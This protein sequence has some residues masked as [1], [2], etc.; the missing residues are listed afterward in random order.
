MN[1]MNIMLDKSDLPAHSLSM[2]GALG[3]WDV[4]RNK[5]VTLPIYV[6]YLKQ[7]KDKDL[8]KLVNSRISTVR[9]QISKIQNLF[10]EHDFEGPT[11]P[12]WEK[13]LNNEP[14]VLSG[15]ILD[16]EEIAMGMKELIR[17][18]IGLET[19]ALRNATIPEVRNLIF[20]LMK[21]GNGDYSSIIKLQKEKGWTDNPP[22]LVQQ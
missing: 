20:S 15:S 12:N 7:V 1:L 13:K 9:S 2:G 10:K 14:F 21:E 6:I 11:E 17:S 22:V 3:L 5:I 4:A 16:D 8:Q 18:V 19:E